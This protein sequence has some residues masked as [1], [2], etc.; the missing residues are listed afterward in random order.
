M[1]VDL[2]V[3]VNNVIFLFF[4]WNSGFETISSTDQFTD[5]VFAY[6][7]VTREG[8]DVGDTKLYING[9]VQPDTTAIPSLPAALDRTIGNHIAFPV[10]AWTGKLDE[11]RHGINL[12]LSGDRI[13][14]EF[15]NQNNVNTFY[16]LGP[17]EVIL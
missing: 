6:F 8:V 1:L 7:V 17:F 4:Q 10:R 16:N 3:S 2:V 11:F 12:V 15:N 9:D 5:S 14:T 13:K